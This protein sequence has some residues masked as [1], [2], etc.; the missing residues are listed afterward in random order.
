MLVQVHQMSTQNPYLL[1]KLTSL[2][3]VTSFIFISSCNNN[4]T[5]VETLNLEWFDDFNDVSLDTNFWN[6]EYG[7]GCPDLCGFGNNEAQTYT[8]SNHNLRVENGK[9]ILSA[10]FD[11]IFKSV[12]LTTANRV[13]FNTGIVEV[14]AKLPNSRGCWPA[15]WLLPTLERPLNWP[16]DGEIDIME[17]VGYFPNYVYGTIHTSTYNHL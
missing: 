11:S 14:S 2:L 3:V 12:K 9:L 5:D 1:N 7:N 8:G 4:K 15:I 6:V 16:L 10:T 13:D 17:N